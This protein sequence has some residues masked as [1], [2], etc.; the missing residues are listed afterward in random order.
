MTIT[1]KHLAERERWGFVPLEVL[2]A[3]FV[4]EKLRGGDGEEEESQPGAKQ[5]WLAR[6]WPP[7]SSDN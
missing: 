5:R 7:S 2:S 4:W 1:S 6:S 3:A